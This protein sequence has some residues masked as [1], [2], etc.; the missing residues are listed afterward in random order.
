MRCASECV[1][2]CMSVCICAGEYVMWCVFACECGYAY[3]YVMS[4]FVCDF[5]WVS[6]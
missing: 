3:R 1:L 6:M 2:V 4:V 5:V